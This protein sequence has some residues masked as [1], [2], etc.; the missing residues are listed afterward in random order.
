MPRRSPPASE[1]DLFS[2]DRAPPRPAPPT[3]PRAAASPGAGPATSADDVGRAIAGWSDD[4]VERLRVVAASELRRRGLPRA[5]SARAPPSAAEAKGAAG[6]A[7]RQRGHGA[8]VQEVAP[9]Q[10]S[11]VR[12]ASQAGMGLGKIAR[13]FGLPL[14]TVKRVLSALAPTGST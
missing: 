11:A 9:G 4:E 5:D 1:P 8:S 2:L 13:E 7:A 6:Q 14:A 3:E 10:A 12:A